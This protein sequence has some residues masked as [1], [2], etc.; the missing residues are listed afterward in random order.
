M[1]VTRCGAL[2]NIARPRGNADRSRTAFCAKNH[3]PR[4]CRPSLPTPAIEKLMG[5]TFARLEH[6]PGVEP[7]VI[8]F[9]ARIAGELKRPQNQ[10]L[11]TTKTLSR[12]ER[13]AGAGSR[14]QGDRVSNGRTCPVGAARSRPSLAACGA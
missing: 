4:T 14:L 8:E 11:W 7:K 6:D 3:L 10:A 1:A 13:G 9:L 2:P 5:A 12:P